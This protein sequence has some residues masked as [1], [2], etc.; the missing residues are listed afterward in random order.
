[1]KRLPAAPAGLPG[2]ITLRMNEAIGNALDKPAVKD[3]LQAEGF[4]LEK[5]SPAEVAA[6]IRA[7]LERWGPLAK[8]LMS[9]DAAK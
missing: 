2:P 1:M 9:S 8:R 6:Y 7:S 4:E 5:M 3:R